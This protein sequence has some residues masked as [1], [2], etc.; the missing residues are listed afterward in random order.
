[1]R[2]LPKPLPYR[3]HNP[4]L[5]L[6]LR[7]SGLRLRQD[8]RRMAAVAATEAVVAVVF[9]NV[10]ALWVASSWVSWLSATLASAVLLLMPLTLEV[11]TV[12]AL[13]C[14]PLLGIAT[15]LVALAG[16]SPAGR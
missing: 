9:V 8:P 1:M 12:V 7:K 6:L 14:G 4:L 10:I 13:M 2:Q 16:D 3:L 11:R 15:H 5:S